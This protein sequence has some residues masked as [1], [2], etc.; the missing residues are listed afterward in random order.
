VAVG[1]VSGTLEFHIAKDSQFSSALGRSPAS[2][3][4]GEVMESVAVIDVPVWA[5]DEY[6]VHTRMTLGQQIFLK[7][8]TQGLDHAVFIGASN[9]LRH[10]QGVIFEMSVIAIYDEV[11]HYTETLRLLEQH[12]LGLYSVTP[13]AREKGSDCLMEADVIFRR[14]W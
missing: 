1:D 4:F 11:P 5:I 8:D 10:V 3:Q 6:A 13:I 2:A 7:V 14:R 12:G 9:L